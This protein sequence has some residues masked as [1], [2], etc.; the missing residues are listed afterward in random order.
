MERRAYQKEEQEN[1]NDGGRKE[2]E[3]GDEIGEMKN[4]FSVYSGGKENDEV[5]K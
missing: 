3:E 2:N 5:K 1:G 4:C